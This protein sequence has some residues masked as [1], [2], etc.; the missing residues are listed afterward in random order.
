MTL[1]EI[2]NRYI[3]KPF[4]LGFGLYLQSIEEKDIKHEK[5]SKKV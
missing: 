3:L 5:T 1:K 2:L 4:I